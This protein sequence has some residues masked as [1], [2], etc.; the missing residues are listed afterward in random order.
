MS[1][2]YIQ[3]SQLDT[4]KWDRCIDNASNGL[5]YGYS[6]YLDHMAKQWDALVL[7]DYEAVMP[8]TWNKKWGI[9]Y[10]YQPAFT[11]SLGLFG[12]SITVDLL[13]RF[14]RAIPTKFR[15]IEIELNHGNA[16]SIATSF[17]LRNNYVLDLQKSY[18]A[19]SKNY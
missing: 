14:I 16:L 10:L 12:G 4:V 8:L 6:F 9:Y 17:F 1:I 3:R 18:E 19:L 2:Q 5:I 13:H 15:L 7:G 11:A